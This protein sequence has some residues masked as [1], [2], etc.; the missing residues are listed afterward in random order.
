VS[1][2]RNKEIKLSGHVKL[3]CVLRK[4]LDNKTYEKRE[5]WREET[6]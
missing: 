5:K 6:D 4:G 3:D 2:K 1:Y